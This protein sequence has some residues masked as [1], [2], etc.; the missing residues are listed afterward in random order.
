LE[1][2]LNT[3]RLSGTFDEVHP[4]PS[5]EN[6]RIVMMENFSIV[7]D[8][9]ML[10]IMKKFPNLKRLTVTQK[11]Y[12]L[13]ALVTNCVRV[14]INTTARFLTFL[15]KLS[16]YEIVVA[17]KEKTAKI[18]KKLYTNLSIQNKTPDHFP[19]TVR[20]NYYSNIYEDNEQLPLMD[21]K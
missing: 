4:M 11:G 7:D 9:F 5:L 13:P 17:T 6:L 3:L 1:G 20:I 15:L 19:T 2:R 16:K 21:L 10:Y 8:T 14:S 12:Y 18:I